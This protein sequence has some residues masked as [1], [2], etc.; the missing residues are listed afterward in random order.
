MMHFLFFFVP[1]LISLEQRESGFKIASKEVKREFAKTREQDTRDL[2]QKF[3]ENI[4]QNK[5]PADLS[6]TW[7][8][9][10]R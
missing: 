9:T 10:L 1:F 3:N 4:F 2:F 5:L 6:I 8:K 7:S